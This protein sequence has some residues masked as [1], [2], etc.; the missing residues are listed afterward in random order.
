MPKKMCHKYILS[1][2][3]SSIVWTKEFFYLTFKLQDYSNFD[4]V[5]IFDNVRQLIKDIPFNVNQKFI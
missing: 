5:I 2:A 3:S 1:W 4:K